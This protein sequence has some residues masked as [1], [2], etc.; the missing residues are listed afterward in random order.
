MF[1]IDNRIYDR[2][3]MARA[4]VDMLEPT[5]NFFV[6]KRSGFSFGS[7][8][9][10]YSP[11]AT[12]LEG[13]SRI[14]WG[15]GPF[16]AGGFDWE[17]IG[18]FLEGLKTGPDKDD[19]YFWGEPKDWDQR[20]VE[21]AAIAFSF[22]LCRERTW[23]MLDERERKNMYEWLDHINNRNF[24]QNNWVC[25]RVM[26]NLAFEYLGLPFRE[27]LIRQDM[28]L[29][30]SFYSSDGWYRDVVPYDM[31][32]PW[33]IQYYTL[34]YYK[35][36]KDK[37]RQRCERIRERT[38]LFAKQYACFFNESGGCVPYGRS[39]TYRFAQA[40]YFSAAAYAG[41]EVLPWGAMKRIVLGN[42]RWWLS[43]PIFDNAGI[44]TVGYRYQ[45]NIMADQYNSPGS[46]YWAFKIFLVL[47]LGEEHP[48]WTSEERSLNNSKS[49][50]LPV[51]SGILVHTDDDDVVFLNNG[52]NPTSRSCQLVDKYAKFAYSIHSGF[53]TT[54]G[55]HDLQNQGGD[56]TLM[57]SEVGEDYFRP[58]DVTLKKW[59]RPDMLKNTWRPFK[60]VDVTTWMIPAGDWHVRIHRIDSPR[61]LDCVEG[62]FAIRKYEGNGPECEPEVFGDMSI[63]YPWGYSA[64]FSITEGRKGFIHAPMSN[65]N[66]M[67]PSVFVPALRCQ[68]EKGTTY[69]A[70]VVGSGNDPEMLSSAPKVVMGEANDSVIINGKV[71]KLF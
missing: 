66:L 60:D 41:I 56:N 18:E 9:A 44:L 20:F 38:L 31:Y 63:S 16:L 2:S 25:F 12:F 32:N 54:V 33:A 5:R 11:Q 45:T 61:K 48:F 30:D 21:M 69:I 43:Q 29:V 10:Q 55:G 46:P 53:T 52:Q 70:A 4:L 51:L 27:D 23:D 17:H 57:F 19:G 68:V 47:A 8:S 7:F 37:D 59:C 58:K 65:T 64:I 39:L 35:L 22:I 67:Y 15:V 24:C 1:E 3:G 34:I 26:V 50:C 40:G 6:G 13:W 49:T 36:R 71:F 28:D 14:L 62:G 42:L